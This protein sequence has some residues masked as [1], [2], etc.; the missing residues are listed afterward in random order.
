MNGRRRRG[1]ISSSI[2]VTYGG[3]DD[4]SAGDAISDDVDEAVVA[5]ANMASLRERAAEIGGGRTRERRQ[6]R[7]IRYSNCSSST[8]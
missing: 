5:A 8:Q 4:G 6:I 1:K 2:I 7:Y 3:D